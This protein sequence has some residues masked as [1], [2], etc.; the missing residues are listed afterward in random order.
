MS[1][2]ELA[3]SI[4]ESTQRKVTHRQGDFNR[5]LGSDEALE[6]YIK[7]VITISYIRVEQRC[8]RSKLFLGS[9]RSCCVY[10]STRSLGS[11][12]AQQAAPAR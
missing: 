9:P 3:Q 11:T 8:Y 6:W 12:A 10:A 1:R 4:D 5:K 2:S 7:A